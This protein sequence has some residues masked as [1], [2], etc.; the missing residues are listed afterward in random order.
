LTTKI[1]SWL[2]KKDREKSLEANTPISL[3]VATPFIINSYYDSKKWGECFS[4]RETKITIRALYR[5]KLEKL[6]GVAGDEEFIQLL[7]ATH[8]SSVQCANWLRKLE[9]FEYTIQKKPQDILVELGRIAARQF[10][11]QRGFANVPQFYRN[12]FVY[13]QGE[14]AKYFERQHGITINRFSR[15]GFLLYV[16]FNYAPVVRN[17]ASWVKLGVEWDEVELVLKLIAMP[18]SKAAKSARLK[19]KTI[20][21]TADKPSVLRQTPCLRFGRNGERIRAPLPELILERVTSGVF[22]DVVIGDGKVRDDYGRRFE[23]YCFGYLS[24]MLPRFKWESEFSYRKKSNTILTPDILCSEASK[25]TIAIECKATRMSHEAMFGKNPMN[26]RGYEDLT[27]AVFQ[28]WRFFSDCRQGHTRREVADEALGV[29]LTLDNWLI[30]ADPLREL[31]LKDATK[32][33]DKS[34]QEISDEDRRPIVF[35]AVTEL[36]R[37]LSTAT[38]VSFK[39]SLAKANSDNFFGWRLD[40]IH[41]ELIGERKCEER[42]YPYAD[43]IGELLPWWDEFGEK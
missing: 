21:H 34:D 17:D 41:R 11:W 15:V 14:C 3:K 5:K 39:E 27:K 29:V 28:L 13:G 16:S 38:E 10:E 20:I 12:A 43:S 30:M 31:V 36:E 9:N 4:G 35:I 22:Y 2:G 37:T 1:H 42:G 24:K 25:V 7:W 18:Y 26:A 23:K 33:A 8:I 32:M 19:R 40:G 6:L